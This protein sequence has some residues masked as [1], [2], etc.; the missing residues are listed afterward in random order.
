M[1]AEDDTG[2]EVDGDKGVVV[3]DEGGL[4]Q[5][6]LS[7]YPLFLLSLSALTLSLLRP[8]SAL[9]LRPFSALT[10]CS[11]SLLLSL[12]S[13]TARA[14]GDAH[15]KQSLRRIFAHRRAVFAHVITCL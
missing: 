12:L 10:L 14:V 9:F 6:V 7:S 2:L 4:G 1:G 8:C 13:G 15:G 3:K 11:C 5:V